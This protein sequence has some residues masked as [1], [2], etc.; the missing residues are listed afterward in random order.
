M[1]KSNKDELLAFL[2]R[3]E[4]K[5]NDV[6]LAL[7][8][9]DKKLDL[10]I[11]KTEF[12]LK[13]INKMDEVQNKLLDQHIEGVNT[14]KLIHDEHVK[15]NNLRFSKLEA[16]RRWFRDSLKILISLGALAGAVAGFMKLF[17]LL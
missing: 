4:G 9:M 5:S 7:A 6:H 10:H 1:A 17:H 14:L 8:H 16:P 12:E 13:Q 11:Q 15:E 3:I 2:Q